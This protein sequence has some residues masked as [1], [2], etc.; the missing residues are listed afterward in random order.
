MSQ[1]PDEPRRPSLSV[2]R[3]L[4]DRHVIEQLLATA[5]LTRAELAARPTSPSRPSRSRSVGLRRPGWWT[6]SGQQLGSS[7]P[8]RHLLPTAS[9]RRGRGRGLRR[10]GRRAGGDPRSR[11]GACSAPAHAGPRADHPGPADPVLGEADRRGAADAPGP[12]L[13]ATLSVAGPV[14]RATGRLV[15][16]PYS[17]FLVDELD[18]V[19]LATTAARARPR[20]S[21]TTSTGPP[22]PSARGQRPRAGRL[23]L[24]LPRSRPRRCGRHRGV[25]RSRWTRSGRRDRPPAHRRCPGTARVRLIEAFVEL[26][27]APSR[28]PGPGSRRRP[29]GAGRWDGRGPPDPGPVVSALA[30]RH[31][32]DRGPAGSRGRRGRRTLE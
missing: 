29:L 25:G 10:A 22:W 21:T 27:S 28:Q 20:P 11:G 16:L 7:R 5:E 1:P 31:R 30:G 2:V 3:E 23:R 6:E 18:P 4:T 26:G 14:D 32:L 12:V 13:A 9:R 19:P 17:P 8:S 24:R 15:Q